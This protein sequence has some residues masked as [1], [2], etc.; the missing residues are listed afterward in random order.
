MQLDG[1][2]LRRLSFF[3]AGPWRRDFGGAV[4]LAW[5]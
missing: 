5:E 2:A 4:D 1:K 3:E